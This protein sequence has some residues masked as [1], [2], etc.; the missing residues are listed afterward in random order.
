MGSALRAAVAAVASM[1][2][3]APAMPAEASESRPELEFVNVTADGVMGNGASSDPVVS[4]DGRYVAFLSEATNLAPGD[5][6][7][8][9]DVYVKD[10]RTRKLRWV[11][12]VPGGGGEGVDFGPPSIS[13]D[14]TR[15]AFASLG[16]DTW[17]PRD[18]A[19]PAYVHDTRTSHTERIDE[20]TDPALRHVWTPLL[21][22]NGRYVTFT[23]RPGGAGTP[24]RI[25]VRD[26]LRDTGSW[27][28]HPLPS[29]KQSL[30]SPTLSHDGSRLAYEVGEAGTEPGESREGV[31]VL[32]RRTGER[33]R[34]DADCPGDPTESGVNEPRI[35]ADGRHVVF[36]RNCRT[37]PSDGTGD[38]RGTFV[39]DV[40]RGTLWPVP[41]RDPKFGTHSA[42][43]SA[44]ARRIAFAATKSEVGQPPLQVVYWR[45]LRSGRVELLSARPDGSLNQRPAA[46]PGIDARGRVVAFD[47]ERL[48][49]QGENGSSERQAVAVRLR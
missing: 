37:L 35:S 47:G 3:V 17:P 34:A 30:G 19:R 15:V 14:G 28:D 36:K 39:R 45:D 33:I 49:L 44:D 26:L 6:D 24:S 20:T 31:Y 38:T 2:A 40:R 21:S 9:A 41:A 18:V 29:G 11:S 10:L 16:P 7:R 13:A 32:D 48:D 5:T 12:D 43:P 46:H 4:A 42:R 27:I 25:Y 23:G 8:T 22:G 1:C